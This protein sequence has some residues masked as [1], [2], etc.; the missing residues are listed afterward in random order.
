[1]LDPQYDPKNP[2]YSTKFIDL[3]KLIQISERHMVKS[4]IQSTKISIYQVLNC[5]ADQMTKYVDGIIPNKIEQQSRIALG[6]LLSEKDK[7]RQARE[8]SADS[9]PSRPATGKKKKE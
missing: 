4:M 1:M 6:T 7:K 3:E 8:S 2:S 9:R 5:I